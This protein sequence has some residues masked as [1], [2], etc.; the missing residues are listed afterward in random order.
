MTLRIIRKAKVS[1]VPE[2]EGVAGLRS[3]PRLL[4][5]ESV[6]CSVD[7]S[8]RASASCAADARL[9]LGPAGAENRGLKTEN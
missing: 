8:E 4:T 9:A 5:R 6:N 2:T 3:S 1:A 7:N